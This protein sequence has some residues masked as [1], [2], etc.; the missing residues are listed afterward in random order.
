M[1][2]LSQT[3]TLTATTTTLIIFTC[4]SLCYP[5]QP[6]PTHG[7]TKPMS[8]SACVVEVVRKCHHALHAGLGFLKVVGHEIYCDPQFCTKSSSLPVRRTGYGDIETLNLTR[9]NQIHR[10]DQMAHVGTSLHHL[11]PPSPQQ[12]YMITY[13]TVF[14]SSWIETF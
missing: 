10:C 13:V 3:A 14:D 11:K 9:T 5:T 12:S 1:N 2:I 4:L 6:N 7:W 8:I